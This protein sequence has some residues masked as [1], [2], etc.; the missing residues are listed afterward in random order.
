M[1][2]DT[3]RICTMKNT[4]KIRAFQK[5]VWFFY[6]GNGDTSPPCLNCWAPAMCLHE[7]VPRSLYPEWWK[8]VLNSVPLCDK[9]HKLCHK[10]VVSREELQKKSEVRAAQ[11]RDEYLDWDLENPPRVSKSARPKMG[12]DGR[13]LLTIADVI[14]KRSGK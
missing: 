12:M 9:C 8:D 4:E 13:S 11:L 2:T 7:I 3:E 6:G 1:N 10:G 5:A 14:R